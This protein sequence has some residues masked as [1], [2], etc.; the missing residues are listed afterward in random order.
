MK[1]WK[2]ANKEKGSQGF[3]GS[4]LRFLFAGPNKKEFS[5]KIKF[6]VI[7]SG[8]VKAYVH[9]D[10]GFKRCRKYSMMKEVMDESR[11]CT[12]C[13]EIGKPLLRYFI[14]V[15]NLLENEK[16][17]LPMAS[18]LFSLFSPY[19][20]K[21]RN[22]IFALITTKKGRTYKYSL[23]AIEGKVTP[24]EVI[25]EGDRILL[26]FE[27]SIGG[28]E[29]KVKKEVSE[30]DVDEIE[31]SIEDEDIDLEEESQG[32]EDEVE[33]EVE[34]SEEGIDEENEEE[35]EEKEEEEED[36]EEDL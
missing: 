22:T 32:L 10:R 27:N 11:Y 5:K 25:K 19:I 26:N 16:Q 8:F 9:W 18:D 35:D 34:K 23:Q 31:E 33:K 13:S 30:E 2:N 1:P 28:F 36:S 29:K 17:I 4:N 14:V 3:S 6:K 21:I 15:K 20:S 7:S 24:E 12:N